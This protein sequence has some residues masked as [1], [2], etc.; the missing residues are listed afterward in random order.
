MTH[1][2][3]KM[4]SD[5]LLKGALGYARRGWAVFPCAPGE[6]VPL[7]PGRMNGRGHKDATVCVDKI[8]RWWGRWPLANVG[9]SCSAL[10]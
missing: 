4:R 10:A 7:I 5:H 9:I 6:K 8:R 1:Q 2:V 3:L